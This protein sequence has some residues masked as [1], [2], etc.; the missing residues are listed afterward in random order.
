M[1]LAIVRPDAVAVPAL[2]RVL[3]T[4]ECIYITRDGNGAFLA[5]I[6][7]VLR[8]EALDDATRREW[9]PPREPRMWAHRSLLRVQWFAEVGPRAHD[10]RFQLSTFDLGKYHR[11]KNLPE[12]LLTKHTSLVSD[13]FIEGI[14]TVFHVGS[15]QD[16]EIDVR[17]MRDVYVIAHEEN[18][19]G[20]RDALKKSAWC[21]LL[22]APLLSSS[23]NPVPVAARSLHCWSASRGT[24]RYPPPVGHI[25]HH[26]IYHMTYI[27]S[28]SLSRSST[29]RT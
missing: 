22:S 17:G 4:G 21:A 27:T 19:S 18:Q 14:V 12:V 9:F 26:I 1:P 2:A 23:P 11:A 3:I 24:P 10:A 7:E 5:R 29:P 25:A 6:V 28:G 16:E 20:H 8:K 15:V 13:K